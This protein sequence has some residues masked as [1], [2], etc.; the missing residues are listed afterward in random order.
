MDSADR[1]TQK[2]TSSSAVTSSLSPAV[3]ELREGDVYRWSYKEPGDNG[4]WGRYHC[5]SMIAIVKNGRLRDTYWQIGGSF[6]P[7][8]FSFGFDDLHRFNLEFLANLT[9]LENRPEYD[10]DYYADEDIVNLNHPN[11]SKGN[12][13]VRR[14]AKRSADKML[15]T[16]Q[17]KIADAE[18]KKR[19]A[20]AT[21]ERMLARIAEIERGDTSGYL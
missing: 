18:S 1:S 9:D 15:A 7:G 10:S 14:G 8:S 19:S 11:S 20:E 21:I 6:S 16:A 12:F 4:A 3:A 13:Y 2:D 17:N 5:K